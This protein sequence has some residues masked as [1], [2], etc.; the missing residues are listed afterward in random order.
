MDVVEIVDVKQRME[1]IR[2]TGY[3]RVN[4]HPTKFERSRIDSLGRCWE[5]VESCR[6]YL[7][8]WDYPAVS[9]K[10]KAFG[11]D[12]VQSGADFRG[13]VEQWRFYQSGQFIHYFS[14]SEDYRD[15][16]DG[17]SVISTLYRVTE[18]FEFAAR[19]AQTEVLEPRLQILIKLV[20]MKGRRLFN[21]DPARY[22]RKEFICGIDE[23]PI[24][25][26]FSAPEIIA[27]GHDEALD[28]TLYIFERFGWLNPSRQI[29]AEDQRKF[30]ERR[31]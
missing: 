31:L 8:G 3:W 28:A 21:W 27:A 2:S 4:I 11:E 16:S 20:H 30:L 1:K 10:E 24:E 29:L 26:E 22:L 17:L 18:I 23:I 13:M 15:A 14:C 9:E 5:L 19:L 6:V 12:W 7:R 25:K